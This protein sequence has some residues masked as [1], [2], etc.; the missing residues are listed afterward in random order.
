MYLLALFYPTV[1]SDN[2]TR[3]PADLETAY[4]NKGK[5]GLINT[6]NTC[7]MN[8]MIQC[9]SHTIEMTDIVLCNTMKDCKV[10]SGIMDW[11][12]GGGSC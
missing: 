10:Y 3:S 7:Y 9:L 12:G 1:G 4:L 2:S 5:V 8:C 6:G 11:G